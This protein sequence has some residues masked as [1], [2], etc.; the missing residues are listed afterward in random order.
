MYVKN[1]IWSVFWELAGACGT[2]PRE[3]I[4]SGFCQVEINSN[5]KGYS[6]F[7]SKCNRNTNGD[8]QECPSHTSVLSDKGR[9]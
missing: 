4:V 8:G 6:N 5:S 3:P 7:N 1:W 9:G 2:L